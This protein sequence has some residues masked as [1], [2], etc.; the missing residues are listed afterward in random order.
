NA[1][2]RWEGQLVSAGAEVDCFALTSIR[3]VDGSAVK[4]L[5]DLT[6][7]HADDFEDD[8]DLWSLFDFVGVAHE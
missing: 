5:N 3:K 4:D 7:L 1:A 2:A 6:S 8:R